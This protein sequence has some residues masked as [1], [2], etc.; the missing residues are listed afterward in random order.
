MRSGR[1]KKKQLK[2]CR[3][4][5]FESHVF[6]KD[7]Q[8]Q[9]CIWHFSWSIYCLL[10]PHQKLGQKNVDWTGD[11]WQQFLWSNWKCSVKIGVSLYAKGKEGVTWSVYMCKTR[12]RLC[13]GLELHFSQ[14]WRLKL[15]DLWMLKSIIR[16]SPITHSPS[17]M[18]LNGHSFI[19]FFLLAWQ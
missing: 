2:N 8:R 6:K 3:L 10:R 11:Q 19:L 9:R 7:D 5:I 1:L 12:W 16:F 4:A 15:M 13:H 18:C 14:C 17:G